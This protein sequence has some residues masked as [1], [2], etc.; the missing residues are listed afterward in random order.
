M[1]RICLV[2]LFTVAFTIPSLATVLT[3]DIDGISNYAAIPQ[4]YGDRVA[5]VDQGSFLYG[6]AGGVTD[7]V[8]VNYTSVT[9]WGSNFNSLLGVANNET[10]GANGFSIQLAADDDYTVQLASFDVGNYSNNL[11][12][13][14]ITV[15]NESGTV[16]YSQIPMQLGPVAEPHRSIVFDAPLQGQSLTIHVDTTGLGN[17]SDNVGLDNIQF[18]QVPEPAT[19][20]LLA[21]GGAFCRRKKPSQRCPHCKN[22]IFAENES[23]SSL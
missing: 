7:H 17:S 11:L 23:Y 22:L 18:S 5:G 15:T 14:G 9:F 21:L 10:D 8:V 19:L 16:L 6:H 20:A 4:S 3:F 12:V 13:P 1:K 2:L